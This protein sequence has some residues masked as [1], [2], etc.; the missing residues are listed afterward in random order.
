MSETSWPT[1]ATDLLPDDG[2]AGTLVGRAW[3]PAVGGPSV[4][5]IREEGVVDCRRPSP[6]CAH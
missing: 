4:V 5:A 2:Y 3:V 6:R 1:D